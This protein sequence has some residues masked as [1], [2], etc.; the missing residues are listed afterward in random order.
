VQARSFR[1][2]AGKYFYPHEVVARDGHW[3]THDGT[4]PL[5]TRFEKMSKSRYNVAS[6]D[7]VVAEHGA[8]SLRLYEMFMG[9]IDQDNLWQSDGLLGTS[10]FLERVW[11]LAGESLLDPPNTDEEATTLALHRL[12]QHVTAD[13]EHLHLNT[14]VSHMMSFLNETAR[15]R[16]LSRK[17]LDAFIRVLAPFAPHIAEELWER[18]GNPAFIL[19]AP[20]PPYDPTRTLDPMATLV[21]QVNGRRRAQLVMPR[22]TT[23][24]SVI[25]EAMRLDPVRKA[26]RGA[27][28]ARVIFLQDKILN[29]VYE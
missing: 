9:P 10:R 26:T 28:P 8:D 16:R 5:Q 29:L 4:T 23:E 2:Q 21:V 7:D 17:A 1:D 18:L 15:Q 6:P 12:I 13:L 14:A 24:T 22:G 27:S 19:D 25:Q 11:R 3:F 20:W